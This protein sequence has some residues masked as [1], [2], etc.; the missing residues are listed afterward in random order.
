MHHARPPGQEGQ[1]V[2]FQRA[3]PQPLVAAAHL[4]LVEPYLDRPDPDGIRSV[5]APAGAADQGTGP[6]HQLPVMEGHVQVVVG[7]GLE[8]GQPPLPITAVEH[9]DGD[10]ARA[11]QDSAEPQALGTGRPQVHHD[12]VGD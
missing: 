2:E 6:G 9:H 3:Q 7:A 4:S 10:V 1:Q 11:S 8:R 12:Q 5:R